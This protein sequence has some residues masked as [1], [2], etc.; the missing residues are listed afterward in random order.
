MNKSVTIIGQGYV[1]L[2]LAQEASASGWKVFGF[3]LSEHVVSG[4]NA[5]QSHIDDISDSDVR[6]MLDNGYT[7]SID[8]LV[9]SKRQALPI[10][11]TLSLHPSRL[12]RI[13]KRAPPSSLSPR[14]TLELQMTCVHRFSLSKVVCLSTKTSLLPSVPNE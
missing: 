4:L 3:D 13:L 10:S 7:A 1:G 11:V 14:L 8:P 12:E 9:I 6:T 5:G 2:P